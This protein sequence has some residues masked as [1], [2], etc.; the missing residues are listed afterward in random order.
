MLDLP[1]ADS[2]KWKREEYKKY[3]KYAEK[4]T[5]RAKNGT[6]VRSKS[7]AIIMDLLESRGIPYR[8]EPVISLNDQSFYPDFLIRHPRTGKLYIWEHLGKTDDA[9][10]LN[11]NMEKIRRYILAGYLPSVDLIITWESQEHPLDIRYVSF[12]ISYYFE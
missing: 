6:R 5:I 1:E 10:Y 8:Y 12:L 3:S 11:S 9:D 4:K 7:E 2:E